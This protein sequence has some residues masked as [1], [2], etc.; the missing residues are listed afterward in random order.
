[1][2]TVLGPAFSQEARGQLAKQ[3][4]FQ[5]RGNRTIVKHYAAPHQP[6]TAAQL[7]HRRLFTF[8]N[9][10]WTLLYAD[11]TTPWDT[12]AADAAITPRNAFTARNLDRF[13]RFL[14]PIDDP[15]APIVNLPNYYNTTTITKTP[16][17]TRLR[18]TSPRVIYPWA[19]FVHLATGTPPTPTLAQLTHAQL[20]PATTNTDVYWYNLTAGTYTA[21]FYFAA[22][23]Y[24]I[25]RAPQTKTFTIP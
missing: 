20:H 21:F 4:I 2:A 12:A 19:L 22:Q 6:D 7:A 14:G 5:Q 18:L 16:P 11:A 17:A 23:G 8:L 1:M 10:Q 13:Y 15:A 24:T 3:F 25:D 9:Q